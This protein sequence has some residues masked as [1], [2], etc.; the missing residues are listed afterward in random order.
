MEKHNSGSLAVAVGL[1]LI[2]FAAERPEA[3]G[4]SADGEKPPARPDI[5][6][7]GPQAEYAA[8]ELR[9]YL[10]RMTGLA[11]EVLK[12]PREGHPCI[13][14]EQVREPSLG[15]DGFQLESEEG[16][17][18]IRGG[19][20]GVIYGAY[21]LLERL[22]CRFFTST[23]EKIPVVEGLVLPEFH[24]THVPRFEYRFHNTA[25]VLENPRF[26]ARCRLNGS[27]RDKALP[28]MVGGA[29]TT[30]GS[31]I[32]WRGSSPWRS[33]AS[34]IPSTTRCA[35]GSGISRRTLPGPRSA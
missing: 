14:L 17:L 15:D 19:K 5:V 8:V 4:Q 10:G 31:S 27:L 18:L 30:S 34:P 33:S 24:E 1:T 26:A 6:F 12:E 16:R 20:R 2:S 28:E 35:T 11:I 22:G 25:E 32:R 23:V 13:Y 9:N 3:P 21:E 7:Q 29:C